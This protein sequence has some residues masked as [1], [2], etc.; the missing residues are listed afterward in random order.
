MRRERRPTMVQE[1]NAKD[2]AST[3]IETSTPRQH[4]R[5]LKDA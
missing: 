1:S 2:E 3:H 4:G 5:R